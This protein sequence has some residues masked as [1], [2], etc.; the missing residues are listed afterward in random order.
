LSLIVT[1]WAIN[2]PKKVFRINIAIAFAI[3]I[4]ELALKVMPPSEF[5]MDTALLT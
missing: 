1:L 3:F 2:L 5:K 4:L